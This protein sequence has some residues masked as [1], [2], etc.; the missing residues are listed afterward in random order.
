MTLNS[1]HTLSVLAVH[2]GT[3]NNINVLLLRYCERILLVNNRYGRKIH[4][5]TYVIILMLLCNGISVKILTID[6]VVN[7]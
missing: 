7:T 2:N 3:V 6:R 5:A 4:H 1:L